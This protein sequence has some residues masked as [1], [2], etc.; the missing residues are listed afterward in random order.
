M[1]DY[2]DIADLL[3]FVAGVLV[4]AGLLFL[5]LYIVASG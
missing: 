1:L 4:G 3:A 5:V 2:D